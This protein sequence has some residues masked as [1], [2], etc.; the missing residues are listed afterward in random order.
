L[1]AEFL[2]VT[3]E[4]FKT[5][6]KIVAFVKVSLGFLA[7]LTDKMCGFSRNDFEILAL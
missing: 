1:P 4:Q 2:I 5:S 7:E 3:V 6:G